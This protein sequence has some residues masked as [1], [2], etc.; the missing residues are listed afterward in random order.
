MSTFV[1][2]SFWW[3]EY[4]DF[5]LINFGSHTN[6]LQL[7]FPIY[8]LDE[9]V[10]QG[11]TGLSCHCFQTVFKLNWPGP[12]SRKC[13]FFGVLDLS[14]NVIQW[15]SAKKG[16]RTKK[17]EEEFCH[18]WLFLATY[19]HYQWQSNF[20]RSVFFSIESHCVTNFSL[21]FCSVLK[22][23]KCWWSVSLKK[24]DFR[25]DCFYLYNVFGCWYV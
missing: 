22:C 25:K 21:K 14:D 5:R 8:Q 19:Q 4:E 2:C 20:T 10:A 18:N 1:C 17:E 7:P 13:L 16:Q 23:T 15:F 3:R 24:N 9:V 11:W 12:R 6:L